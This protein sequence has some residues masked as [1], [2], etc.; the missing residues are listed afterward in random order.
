MSFASGLTSVIKTPTFSLRTMETNDAGVLLAALDQNRD[1][2]GE[3]GE[4]YDHVRTVEDA[5]AHIQSVN[6]GDEIA[7]GIFLGPKIVGVATLAPFPN[8]PGTTNIAYWID[9]GFE[10]HGLVSWAVKNIMDRAFSRSLTNNFVIGC[11]PDHSRSK[12]VADR[13]GFSF[14][15]RIQ[16]DSGSPLL[17]HSYSRGRWELDKPKTPRA[18]IA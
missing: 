1:R 15:G 11:D 2:L 10:G 5:K 4:T 18:K 8:I 9:R 3:F 17:I 7:V 13:L 16:G 12:G 14:K 6:A